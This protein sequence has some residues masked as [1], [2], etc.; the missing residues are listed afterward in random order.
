M[1]T[2]KHTFPAG[3]VEGQGGGCGVAEVSHQVILVPSPTPSITGLRISYLLGVLCWN[4]LHK[5]GANNVPD[6]AP[7]ILSRK[8]VPGLCRRTRTA[9]CAKKGLLVPGQP[10]QSLSSCS[11]C[12]TCLPP[13]KSPPVGFFFLSPPSF[14]FSN[15]STAAFPVIYTGTYEKVSGRSRGRGLE[16]TWTVVL[17]EIFLFLIWERKRSQAGGKGSGRSRSPT[18]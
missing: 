11:G 15:V 18:E 9:N 17:F 16:D 10:V 3:E 8:Q 13:Q 5:K 7:L 1:Y 4:T 14:F 6:L 2:N 12:K